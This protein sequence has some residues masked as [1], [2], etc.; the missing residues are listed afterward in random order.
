[1]VVNHRPE[2]PEWHQCTAV[3]G[4]GTQAHILPHS[5]A[6]AHQAMKQKYNFALI[7]N[8]KKQKKNQGQPLNSFDIEIISGKTMK[9]SN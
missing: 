8:T 3:S 7:Q 1:M 9:T 6:R 5:R 2:L 4:L